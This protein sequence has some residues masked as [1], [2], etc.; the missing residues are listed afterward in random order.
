MSVHRKAMKLAMLERKR[1]PM[2][3][4]ALRIFTSMRASQIAS[5]NV[6]PIKGG[7]LFIGN[8]N[9]VHGSLCNE[10]PCKQE[11]YTEEQIHMYL[12]H[13]RKLTHVFVQSF[14]I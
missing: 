6:V 2:S 14:S 5:S 9:D 12:Q 10:I 1:S 13:A 8:L 4:Y 7:K 11:F 3:K